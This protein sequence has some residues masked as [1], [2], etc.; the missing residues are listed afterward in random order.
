MAVTT[1]LVT[2]NGKPLDSGT[3][4]FIPDSA[5]GTT[6]PTGVGDIDKTGHDRILTARQ[7]GAIVGCHQIR[8]WRSTDQAGESVEDPDG[9]L[10]LSG[11]IGPGGR[12]KAGQVNDIPSH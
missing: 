12:G 6:G 10:R 7:D 5:K 4:T 1:G 2:F 9:P 11:G 3:V 8:A